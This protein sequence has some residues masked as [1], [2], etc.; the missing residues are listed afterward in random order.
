MFRKQLKYTFNV[1]ISTVLTLYSFEVKGHE[2]FKD[3]CEKHKSEL[4]KTIVY[5]FITFYNMENYAEN[6]AKCLDASRSEMDKFGV[7]SKIRILCD[8]RVGDLKAIKKAFSYYPQ[9]LR[10]TDIDFN[11]VNKGCSRS[12]YIQLEKS[13]SEVQKDI[14]DNKHV[15]FSILD[16]DDIIHKDFYLF[17]SLA[18]LEKDA[19]AVYAPLVVKCTKNDSQKITNELISK[20]ICNELISIEKAYSVSDFT[21]NL[22]K[23]EKIFCENSISLNQDGLITLSP[24]FGSHYS[25]VF[26][27]SFSS[28][29]FYVSSSTAPYLNE[30]KGE[31]NEVIPMYF[32]MQNPKSIEHNLF[33]SMFRYFNSE[34]SMKISF[35]LAL[36]KFRYVHFDEVPFFL[37]GYPGLL[38]K[39]A[40][41][42]KIDP[43]CNNTTM[44]LLLRSFKY[45]HIKL[46]QSIR[47]V[48]NE[49]KDKFHWKYVRNCIRLHAILNDK[50][51]KILLN[52]PTT[53][54][55]S[56]YFVRSFY[57]SLVNEL[58]GS[59]KDESIQ[60][61]IN[62]IPVIKLSK[63]DSKILKQY[64]FDI[65]GIEFA[66]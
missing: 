35:E 26:E 2:N 13:I 52:K 60:R 42:Y 27:V 3:L 56:D 12:R 48:L 53:E 66:D 55:L 18:I 63:E 51:A 38:D 9:T 6:L 28:R 44:D 65:S 33:L 40:A 54:S 49:I 29:N 61:D 34:K 14:S 31:P 58:F 62:I 22:F 59:P 7:E 8:G 41:D 47:I 1:L 46:R 21:V 16:G 50:R 43:N 32:Y 64:G 5:Q 45:N 10:V 36:S 23:A 15:Y 20:D 25:D 17:M 19:D 37:L 30:L 39:S 11:Q 4:N 24:E 57:N